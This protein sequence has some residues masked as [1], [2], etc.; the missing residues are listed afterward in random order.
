MTS[1]QTI[2]GDLV[3]GLG[4]LLALAAAGAVWRAPRTAF[5]R[6]ILV[7]AGTAELAGLVVIGISLGQRPFASPLLMALATAVATGFWSL[8]LCPGNRQAQA[9]G[10]L[11]VA[12]ALGVFLLIGELSWASVEVSGWLYGFVEIQYALAA[13]ALLLGSICLI[14]LGAPTDAMATRSAVVIALLFQ[15]GGL[16]LLGTSG[17]L[18]W[19]AFWSW[20]PIECWHLAGWLATAISV[21]GIHWLDWDGRRAGWAVCLSTA[22]WLFVLYGSL[23]LVRWLGLESHFPIR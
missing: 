9:V 4:V 14:P 7:I 5:A 15:T 13:G 18:A 16:V 12:V 6:A 23:P 22:F 3:V 1:L 19:G 20:D 21:V 10:S 8:V 17:Q 11:V 2:G